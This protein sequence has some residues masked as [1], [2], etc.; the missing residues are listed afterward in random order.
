MV[1]CIL[2]I[3]YYVCCYRSLNVSPPLLPLWIYFL[4]WFKCVMHEMMAPRNIQMFHSVPCFLQF[5]RHFI[6]W[7]FYRHHQQDRK[8]Q[9]APTNVHFWRKCASTILLL[10]FFTKKS[11]IPLRC[12]AGT[13]F[14]KWN[15]S[16]FCVSL[17]ICS[18]FCCSHTSWLLNRNNDCSAWTIFSASLCSLNLPVLTNL[19]STKITQTKTYL[20]LRMSK[21]ENVDLC[22][23]FR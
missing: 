21:V 6:V 2:F 22:V 14:I 8:L 7:C 11:N 5:C 1:N 23:F 4:W 20:C 15:T 19:Y 12:F 18:I 3:Y 13:V 9:A 17:R 10:S 16:P